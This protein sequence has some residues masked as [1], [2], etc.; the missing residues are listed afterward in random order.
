[1]TS[2]LVLFNARWCLPYLKEDNSAEVTRL[3]DAA[4]DGSLG[5]LSYHAYN[6][7]LNGKADKES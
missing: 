5:F 7:Q 2:V 4:G 3:L 6:W 1:M